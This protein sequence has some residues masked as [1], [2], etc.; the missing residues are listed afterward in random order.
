MSDH[1]IFHWLMRD[2]DGNGELVD[3]WPIP[4]TVHYSD[5]SGKKQFVAKMILVFHPIRY[6]MD[7]KHNLGTRGYQHPLWEF[8]DIE[9]TREA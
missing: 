7:E 3:E 1:D 2:W 9:F 5:F 6:M 8:R 4:L